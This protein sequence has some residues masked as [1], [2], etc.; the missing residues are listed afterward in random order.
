MLAYALHECRFRGSDKKCVVL[1]PGTV[2]EVP[3]E[4]Y[5][6]LV[7]LDAVRP[8]TEDEAQLYELRNGAKVD[9]APVSVP[10]K[11]VPVQEARS[12]TDAIDGDVDENQVSFDF[13]TLSPKHKG[14]G[15]FVVVDSSGAVVAGEDEAFASKQ[16]AQEWIDAQSNATGE[17]TDSD[18]LL[19]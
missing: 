8:A 18:D 19:G 4:V 7:K 15:R 12:D 5:R 14:G 9:A 17:S 1:D 16:A 13:S 10:Q 3:N 6:D 11:P 2:G